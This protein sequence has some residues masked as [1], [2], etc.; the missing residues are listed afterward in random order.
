VTF[1]AAA[2][3][4]ALPLPRRRALIGILAAALVGASPPLRAQRPE[5]VWRIGVLHPVSVESAR[6]DEGYIALVRALEALGYVSGRNLVI[7]HRGADG[8]PA[9]LPALA[10]ELA[11]IPVDLIVAVS[12]L[13]IRAARD[14]TRTIPIV[15]AF[16]GDD[17]VKSG[18][19]ASYSR[20]G[21]NITGMTSVARELAPK[22]VD[23]LCGAVPGLARI[24]VLRGPNRPDHSEQ[25]AAMEAAGL[26]GVE[27]RV[28]IVSGRDE[29]DAAFDTM[30]RE[31][32]QALIV[33]SG[34]EF[35]QHRTKLADLA[36]AHRLPSMFQFRE[37]V[38]AGAQMSY[39]PDIGELSARA[40]VFV[41]KILK[42][43][44]PGRLAVQMP[45]TFRLAI[46]LATARRLGLAIPRP[47]LL[48]ADELV[49]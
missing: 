2:P 20:P 31:R 25:I 9:R 37:F 10:A 43:A 29:Y 45:T 36:I 46:N 14:A 28:V 33:L 30:T 39:G 17:P 1:D 7:E 19:I 32:A 48:R 21:G 34:P 5:K 24:A 23:L 8:Q 15:M 41:D 49:S 12:P 35:T 22:W 27:L 3:E 4:R 38:A 11:A 6:R 42:G 44:D 40:A 18:F 13:P 16:S 26:A 47:L